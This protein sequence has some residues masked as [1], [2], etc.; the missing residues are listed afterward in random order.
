MNNKGQNNVN[1]YKTI[2]LFNK[3]IEIKGINIDKIVGIV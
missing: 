3:F 2:E 1:K